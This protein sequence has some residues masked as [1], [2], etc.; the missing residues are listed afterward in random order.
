MPPKKTRRPTAPPKPG[1]TALCKGAAIELAPHSIR[2]NLVAPGDIFTEANA[3]IIDEVTA[4]GG[5]GRFFRHTPLGR[6]RHCRSRL[7]MSSLS[8]PAMKP[9][10]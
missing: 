3:D 4:S 10:S 8:S 1:W 9:A 5:S 7:A 2:V 6:P